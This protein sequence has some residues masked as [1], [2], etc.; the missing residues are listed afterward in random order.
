MYKRKKQLKEA[1]ETRNPANIKANGKPSKFPPP[2][3]GPKNQQKF[4]PITLNG[5]MREVNVGR[6]TR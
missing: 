2:Q 6:R 3:N 4:S 5:K 1:K